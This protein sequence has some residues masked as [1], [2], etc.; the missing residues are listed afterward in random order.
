[1]GAQTVI[2]AATRTVLVAE[3][4]A[5]VRERFRTAL[6]G[7][8]HR[9]LLASSR[10]ELVAQVRNTSHSI[11]LVV[12][13]LRLSDSKATALVRQLQTLLPHAPTIVAFSGTVGSPATVRE[14]ASLHVTA[15][16]NE[17]TGEQHIV[18][19]LEPF[20]GGDTSC[21]RSSPR[22]AL[23]TGVTFRH[24][25]TIVTAVTLN[26]SRG[27]IAIRSTSPLPLGTAVRLRL[28][29]PSA[30]EVEADARVVWSTP[31]SGMGLQFTMVTDDH[32][33]AIDTFVNSHFFDNRKG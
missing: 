25:Q 8:G 23:G 1:V 24:G 26:I 33:R 30:G 16:I 21:Q 20:L 15:F 5:F 18:R 9:V 3:E 28:R 17:Y 12:L 7:A 2:G 19:A 4:T 6:T 13:D 10:S 22:V 11:D 31:G 27:G 29:L 32:Q 14:L